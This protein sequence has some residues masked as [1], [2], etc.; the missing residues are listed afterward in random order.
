[1]WDDWAQGAVAAVV[2][3]VTARLALTLAARRGVPAARP[4]GLGAAVASVVPVPAA[5]AAAVTVLVGCAALGL[6]FVAAS[7]VGLGA[8]ELL[9]R[10]CTVRF[11]GVT[12]DVFGAL[13]GTATT[14]VLVMLTMF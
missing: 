7:V 11:G 13:E 2:A 10:R 5:A 14:A 6:P 4:E 9:L 1:G 3:A 12:G 8:A